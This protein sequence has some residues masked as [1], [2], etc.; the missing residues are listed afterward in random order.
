MPRRVLEK[1]IEQAE[2]SLDAASAL[3]IKSFERGNVEPVFGR[4]F[5]ALRKL[6][7][8]EIG[9][10]QR[11]KLA[12]TR[13]SI[14][15]GEG[16]PNAEI[17]FVGEGPGEKEDQTG[18]P[19]VGAAGKILTDIIERGIRI[20]REKVFIANVVK[21]RPPGNRD[22][23]PDEVDSCHGFLEQQIKIVKPRVVVALG[24]VAAGFLLKSEE[25]ISRVR[26]NWH[27]FLGFPVMPTFHPAYLLHNPG[28]KREVW[29][30][31]K[32][33]LSLLAEEKS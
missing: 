5:A 24:R 1:I 6:K 3:G 15:F 17:F 14:V 23:E 11:C 2:I 29:N 8:S 31:I 10:C 12:K 9:D 33:V 7:D 21:C 32:Q 27:E 30:D 19:F 28:A 18:R 13:F 22:P 4:K 20:P 16:D 25:P 26:G